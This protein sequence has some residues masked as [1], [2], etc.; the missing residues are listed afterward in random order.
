VVTVTQVQFSV[1][2]DPRNVGA[3]RTRVGDLA[4]AAGLP[5]TDVGAVRLCVTE[6]MANAIIHGYGGTGGT[7]DVAIEDADHELVVVVRDFGKGMATRDEP[8]RQNG[9]GLQIIERLTAR[10]SI[11]S[12]PDDGTEVR[13]SFASRRDTA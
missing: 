10:C 11:D 1:R 7:I 6:A 13:M 2:A 3:V 12:S 9:F 8:R 4:L 5:P